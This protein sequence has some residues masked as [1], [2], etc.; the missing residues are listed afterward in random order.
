MPEQLQE[1]RV[2]SLDLAAM[3]A[4]TRYRGDFEER[5]TALMDEISA[6]TA[7]LIVFIDELHTVV[8]AGGSGESGGMD[9]GN[10]IKPRLARGDLHLV[11]AT[12]LKEYRRI[13]KD[14]ALER[15]FQPVTVGEPSVEDAVL[16]LDGLRPAYEDHH[17]VRYTADAIRAAVELSDRYVSDR[18]LPDKAID[19]IDQAGARL[20]LSLG[21]RVDTS[22]LME[23]L[24][25][26]ES[27][28]NSAVAAEHYE[29]ASRLRDEIETVQRSLDELATAPRVEAVVG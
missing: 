5:L 2:V 20:R 1:K 29:E 26:L 3:V 27:E 17:G 4:G 14:P 13:E 15:R 11:G 7:E 10:I 8:G 12:T 25:T 28:K 21:K 23:R 6:G 19:L 9:A 22:A 24:A 18:F 16:I